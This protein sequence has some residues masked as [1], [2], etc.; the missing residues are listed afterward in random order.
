MN[1]DGA[2]LL[3]LA[4]AIVFTFPGQAGEH[5]M[6]VRQR[7]AESFWREVCGE[8]VPGD[9]VLFGVRQERW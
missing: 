7:A 5:P 6:K 8:R 9:R 2:G 1:N 4:G 3:G